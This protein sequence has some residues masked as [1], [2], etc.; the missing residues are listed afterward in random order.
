MDSNLTNLRV[1]RD[2]TRNQNMK[3]RRITNA[4]PSQSP[5]DY[6]TRSELDKLAG[7]GTIQ[8]TVVFQGTPGPK[9]DKGAFSS[10]HVPGEIENIFLQTLAY[11][12]G[13]IHATECALG[14]IWLG[15]VIDIYFNGPGKLIKMDP[16]NPSSYQVLTFPNDGN[17][18]GLLD[19]HYI[20]SKNKIYC[21]F[22]NHSSVFL[23]EVDPNTLTYTD[24]IADT[25]SGH[26]TYEG[27][28]CYDSTYCYIACAGDSPSMLLRYSL[29]TWGIPTV[30]TLSFSGKDLLLSH[31]CRH[32]GTNIFISSC[33][34]DLVTYLA[35]VCV[36]PITYT[37]TDGAS[38]PI[39]T[40]AIIT[41]DSTFTS[42]YVWYGSELS[43]NIIRVLKSNLSSQTVISMGVGASCYG[44]YFDGTYIWGIF[45]TSPGKLIRI[46]TTDLS[47]YTF[48]FD[49][50][51]DYPN[52]MLQ[53]TNGTFY[54]TFWQDPAKVSAAT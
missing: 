26:V 46:R 2:T 24:V 1:N 17:H 33:N 13:Y 43:G 7:G 16:L 4:A 6:V 35:F 25:I 39:N 21:L 20:A 10:F 53:D 54:F 14:Y 42:L 5:S 9:G 48:T 51:Q 12:E 27:S 41:D 50:G 47:L 11:G 3:G 29:T 36:D 23:S 52:E 40:N 34:N 19:L 31:N 32:D 28:F 22:C 18:Q 37:V 8:R 15:L 45:N 38:L 44:A 49:P 30:L